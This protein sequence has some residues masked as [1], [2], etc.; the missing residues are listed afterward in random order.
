MKMGEARLFIASPSFSGSYCSQYVESLVAT[1]KDCQAHGIKTLYKSL[2]G[3][4]WID[5]ARDILA[6]VFLHTDCTHMLQVDSDLG[7]SADAPRR[8]VES[9]KPIVGGVYPLRADCPSWPVKADG[10]VTGLP[11]GFLMVKREVI[12]RM[13]AGLPKYRCASIQFGALD[14]APLFQREFRADSYTGED[15]AFCNRARAAGYELAIEP[16]IDF[17]HVGPK[18]F[19]GN[20]GASLCTG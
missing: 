14:V 2:D 17:K 10:E 5:I 18:A 19:S 12:E 20:Y 15:Y 11:G 1:I 9:A 3:V 8:M 16:D 13:S 6:H 7:W 4:H